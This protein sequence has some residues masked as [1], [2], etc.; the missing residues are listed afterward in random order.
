MKGALTF[1]WVVSATWA[2]FGM[3]DWFL[4]DMR[5]IAEAYYDLGHDKNYLDFQY[6]DSE[7]FSRHE[8][9]MMSPVVNSL[10]DLTELVK[11]CVFIGRGA[12]GSHLDGALQL[13]ISHRLAQ[14]IYYRSV[15]AG[16]DVNV[17]R[18]TAIAMGTGV[19]G[20]PCVLGIEYNG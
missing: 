5:I 6:I 3:A 15:L 17:Y 14:K 13:L 19:F 16:G 2:S 10:D 9:T 12:H 18:S 8:S 1:L 20:A 11:E 4:H 7:V